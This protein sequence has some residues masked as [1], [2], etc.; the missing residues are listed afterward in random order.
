MKKIVL[1]G[2]TIVAF[3]LLHTFIV[4]SDTVIFLIL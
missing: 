4:I 3:L 2:S 1:N